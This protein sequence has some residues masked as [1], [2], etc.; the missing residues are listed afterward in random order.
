[1]LGLHCDC[2]PS[3]SV[4]QKGKICQ[5]LLIK[6]I[7]Y[8]YHLHLF[9]SHRF[10]SLLKFPFLYPCCQLF[11]LEFLAYYF[12]PFIYVINLVKSWSEFWFCYCYPSLQYSTS[13]FSSIVLW[14]PCILAPSSAL[15]LLCVPIS[16]RSSPCSCSSQ[17]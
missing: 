3:I 6:C 13:N 10:I 1:M 5:W 8:F 16:R 14:F 11:L 15:V 12:F 17:L 7:F 2:A 4:S 9:I